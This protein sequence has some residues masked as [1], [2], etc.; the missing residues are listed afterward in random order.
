MISQVFAK[1]HIF[2]LTESI[3]V[4]PSLG[5][6]L[7]TRRGSPFFSRPL[8]T[9]RRFIPLCALQ[10]IIINEGLHRWDVRYYLALMNGNCPDM[11]ILEVAYEVVMPSFTVQNHPLT[12]SVQNILPY[13]DVLVYVYRCLQTQIPNMAESPE[14]RFVHT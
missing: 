12:P 1:A 8:F 5:V 4:L 6:Q 11:I 7:E 13:H 14:R 9:G 10:D 3:V 2:T